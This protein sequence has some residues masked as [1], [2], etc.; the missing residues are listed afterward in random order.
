MTGIPQAPRRGFGLDRAAVI[1]SGLC[2]LHCAATVLLAAVLAS[3]GAALANPAWHEVGFT[4]AIGL[5]AVALGRG[6][7][8]HR[9]AGP[10]LLGGVGLA[11]MAAGLFL[12]HG[13]GEIG[14][15]VAGVLLLAVAHRR[16]ARAPSVAAAS[17]RP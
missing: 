4:L 1:L 3:A 7:A 8:R 12:P 16:N 10:L 17:R 6:F 13:A 15:T 11:L 14:T 5:G 2:V 9:D